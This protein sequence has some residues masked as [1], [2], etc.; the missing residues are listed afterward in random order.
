[1]N[2]VIVR[3]ALGRRG[4]QGRTAYNNRGG[5]YRGLKSGRWKSCG[6]NWKSPRRLNRAGQ[7]FSVPEN[8]PSVD[9]GKYGFSGVN[10]RSISFSL[11]PGASLTMLPFPLPKN[12]EGLSGEEKWPLARKRTKTCRRKSR[13]MTIP[14]GILTAGKRVCLCQ[15]MVL[16]E[17]AQEPP[18]GF[19][20][21]T[22]PSRLQGY[23][24]SPEISQKKTHC[25]GLEIP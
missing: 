7:T 21:H 20:A 15:Q 19:P 24:F 17:I 1:M 6:W 22:L 3:A 5:M 2:K 10:Q 4:F 23:N 12:S 13:T 25:H 14:A 8:V 16:I 9:K 18:P 11:L